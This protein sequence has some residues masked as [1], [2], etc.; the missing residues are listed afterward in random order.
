VDGAAGGRRGA[1]G[2]GAGLERQHHA[3]DGRE[4]GPAADEQPAG[5]RDATS[6]HRQML[7]DLGAPGQRL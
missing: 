3:H 5:G 1:G 6:E 7:P 2:G 4:Q